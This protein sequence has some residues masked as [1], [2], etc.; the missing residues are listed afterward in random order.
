MFIMAKKSRSTQIHSTF[1]VSHSYTNSL[2]LNTPKGVVVYPG[3]GKD[4]GLDSPAPMQVTE[5]RYKKNTYCIIAF[6]INIQEK[7]EYREKADKWF[8]ASAYREN[9]G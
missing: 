4:N 7:N 3:A 2:P 6:I 5:T 1:Q 8:S 9:F